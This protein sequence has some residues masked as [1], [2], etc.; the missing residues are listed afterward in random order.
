MFD[1]SVAI[2]T[3]GESG[4]GAACAKALGAS[5]GGC[6]LA[7]A[8]KGREDELARALAPFGERLFY[9]ID[10]TGFTVIASSDT[11]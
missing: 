8:D 2:V 1:D 10:T 6:V 7:F 9:D 3:G 4:I 5:G 11:A